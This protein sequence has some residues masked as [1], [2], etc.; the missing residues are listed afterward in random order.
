M[1]QPSRYSAGAL[2]SRFTPPHPPQLRPPLLLL[3]SGR[4]DLLSLVARA[5]TAVEVRPLEELPAPGFLDPERPTVLLADRALLQRTRGLPSLS[6][7]S[8]AMAIIAFGDP[9]DLEPAPCFASDAL[10]GFLP[11]R[12]SD[13]ATRVALRAAVTSASAG[14][15]APTRRP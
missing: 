8:E 1:T 14:T 15:A 7:L 9:G 6:E 12:T 10:C 5:M 13:G 4:D 11:E 3:P 2:R